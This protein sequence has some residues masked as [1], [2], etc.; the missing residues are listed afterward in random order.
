[1]SS[2]PRRIY[3]FQSAILQAGL[4]IRLAG[5]REVMCDNEFGRF[6]GSARLVQRGED[7]FLPVFRIEAANRSVGPYE[8]GLT[9]FWKF[10]A[11]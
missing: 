3:A 4:P 1:M 11:S 7:H 8:G 2:V 6:L 5:Y 10:L 9:R